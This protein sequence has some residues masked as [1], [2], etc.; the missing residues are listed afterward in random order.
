MIQGG[1][2]Q[3]LDVHIQTTEEHP[4]SDTDKQ[5]EETLEG[6]KCRA[7]LKEVSQSHIAS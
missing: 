5:E 6:M 3:T 7:P 4:H 2:D 1:D